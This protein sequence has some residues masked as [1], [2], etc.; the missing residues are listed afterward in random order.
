MLP[1]TNCTPIPMRRGATALEVA[2]VIA[3]VGMLSA[4]VLAGIAR[5]RNTAR[6]NDCRNRLRQLG[7]ATHSFESAHNGLPAGATHFYDLLPYIGQKN[8]YDQLQDFGTKDRFAQLRKTHGTLPQ[9]VCP[10][11]SFAN[12]VEHHVSFRLNQGTVWGFDEKF[13]PYNGMV[14]GYLGKNSIPLQQVRDGQSNT[15]LYS[16]RLARMPLTHLSQPRADV[17]AAQNQKRFWWELSGDYNF[18]DEAKLVKDCQQELNRITFGQP[19]DF[20]GISLFSGKPTWYDHLATPNSTACKSATNR[21]TPPTSQHAGGV[22]ALLVD[23]SVKFVNESIDSAV[24]SALGTRAGNELES[25]N[26]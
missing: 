16:E 25:V 8:L 17:T 3:C 5:A 24:W 12:P 6:A 4:L 14:S 23:G 20:R 11:D 15:L 2:V 10:S 21:I 18:G 13:F 9:F 7:V 19:N 22:N 26:W 1:N